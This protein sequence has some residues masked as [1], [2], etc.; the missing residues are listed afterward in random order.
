L[1][2]I[3]YTGEAKSA[4]P[5]LLGYMTTSGWDIKAILLARLS[6]RR[7]HDVSTYDEQLMLATQTF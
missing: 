5:P 1:T 7:P 2:A 3:A 4:L 6:L